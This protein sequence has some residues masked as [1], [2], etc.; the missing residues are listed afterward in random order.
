M[1][2]FL[3]YFT[4]HSPITLTCHKVLRDSF[5]GVNLFSGEKWVKKREN[6]IFFDK[7]HATSCIDFVLASICQQRVQN[8]A[9]AISKNLLSFSLRWVHYCNHNIN[10]LK[11]VNIWK[12]IILWHL[13]ILWGNLALLVSR[14]LVEKLL[15]Q[16]DAEGIHSREKST[17]THL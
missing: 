17:S 16:I 14:H 15:Q 12:K 5:L 8:F 2:T 3:H 1:C 10:G 13:N 7:I 6:N 4:L 11:G 9:E